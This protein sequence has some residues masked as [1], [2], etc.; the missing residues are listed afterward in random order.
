M[1]DIAR[2]PPPAFHDLATDRWTRPWWDALAKRRLTAPRCADCGAYRM[3][4]T[5]FCP[6][7]LSQALDWPALSGLGTV[8]SFTV[9]RRAI[10]PGMEAH[11]PYVPALIDL[12]DA[13]GARLI[14]CIVDTPLDRIAIGARVAIRWPEQPSVGEAPRFAVLY[15]EKTS[16]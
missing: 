11:L 15:S 2:P 10:A 14:G 7:C 16:P 9:V 5:P 1:T 4:P 13:P 3:P 8:F 12:D 6:E